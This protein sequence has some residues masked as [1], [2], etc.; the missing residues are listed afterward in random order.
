MSEKCRIKLL[1]SAEFQQI[2]DYFVDDFVDLQNI[3]NHNHHFIWGARGSGKSMLLKY[4]EASC[5]ADT[6]E[7]LKQQKLIDC[8]VKG[9]IQ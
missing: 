5:Q 1:K 8:P 4:I 6:I 9:I 2:K 3:M 7:I